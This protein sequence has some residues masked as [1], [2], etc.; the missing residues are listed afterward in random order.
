[1]LLGRMRPNWRFLSAGDGASGLQLAR[2]HLPRLILLDLQLPTMNGDTVLT[3]LRADPRT[4][5][6]P[7]L[8]PSADATA[9]GRERL[10]WPSGRTTSCRNPSTSLAC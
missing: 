1:M 4:H 6:I 7:V 10:L 3:E 2:E 8:L 9:Q 5:H